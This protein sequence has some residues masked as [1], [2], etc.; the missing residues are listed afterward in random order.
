MTSIHRISSTAVV[1]LSLAA[2]SAPAAVYSPQD[3]S[4]VPAA[5]PTSAVVYSGQDKSSVPA[6]SPSSTAGNTAKA[7]AAPPV[8][9]VQ[10]P[11]NSFDWGDAGIGAAGGLALSM[12][13]VG[14]ALA[15]S[16]HRNRDTTA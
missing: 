5:N 11:A 2:A 1:I 14:G 4:L 16:Q 6:T 9:R 13:G 3:K 10:A 8:V 7:T 15:L 12:I